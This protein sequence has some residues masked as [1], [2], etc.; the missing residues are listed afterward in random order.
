LDLVVVFLGSSTLEIL[1]LARKTT[2]DL[3]PRNDRKYTTKGDDR[4]A[5]GLKQWSRHTGDA[6]VAQLRGTRYSVPCFS[7]IAESRMDQ[8]AYLETT[9]G[10]HEWFDLPETSTAKAIPM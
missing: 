1:E 5:T 3:K 10:D 2:P 9:I 8:T 4:G 7:P 6:A